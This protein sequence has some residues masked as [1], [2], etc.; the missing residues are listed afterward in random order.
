MFFKVNITG[1]TSA[2]ISISGNSGQYKINSGSY[3]AS[4]GTIN[5]GDT[6]T[7]K[8][9]S[10][11]NCA[12]LTTT[13]LTVAGSSKAY[14]VSTQMPSPISASGTAVGPIVKSGSTYYLFLWTV[15]YNGGIGPPGN[16]GVATASSID[17]PWTYN[18][19]TVILAPGTSGAWDSYAVYITTVMPDTT[20]SG[21]TWIA[22]YG[23][24]NSSDYHAGVGVAYSNNLTTWVKSD[25]NP[26]ITSM[27]GSTN[28]ENPYVFKW[29][30][31]YYMMSNDYVNGIWNAGSHILKANNSTLL[32]WTWQAMIVNPSESGWDSEETGMA[33]PLVVGDKVYGIYDGG[34][35]TGTNLQRHMYRKLGQFEINGLPELTASNVTV[36]SGGLISGGSLH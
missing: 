32:S 25:S 17:G 1:C 6:V 7:V 28:F 24:I 19:S 33:S 27:N 36:L 20:G 15:P 11:G 16:M 31:D 34:N 23:A 12:T 29:G 14:N 30:S 18:P 13:T 3:T 2:A 9:T 4:S 22:F 10:S 5:T 8:Q 26:I 21:Y 35:Q